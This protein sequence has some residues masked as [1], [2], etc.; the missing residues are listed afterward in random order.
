MVEKLISDGWCEYEIAQLYGGSFSAVGILFAAS[1]ERPRRRESHQN[2]SE[3]ICRAFTIDEAT[4][5]TQHIEDDCACNHLE[6]NHGDLCSIMKSGQTAILRLEWSESGLLQIKALPSQGVEY[7]AI[8]HVWSD[9]L[10]NAVA[11]SLPTCQLEH[12][13]RLVRRMRSIAET[14]PIYL[15]IDTLCVT[16]RGQAKTCPTE[17]GELN[18]RGL[19]I[20]RMRDTYRDAT[21]VLVLDWQLQRSSVATKPEESL[22]RILTSGWMRRLWTFQEAWLSRNLSVQFRDRAVHLKHLLLS[23]DMEDH[24]PLTPG[25]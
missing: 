7:V 21:D 19:A 8:S 4:Y 20:R 13:D 25:T 2:C 1:L 6:I 23:L 24:L 18:C 12:L 3:K 5:K 14:E 17:I 22:L 9:G 10:G 16:A 15:W 11:N